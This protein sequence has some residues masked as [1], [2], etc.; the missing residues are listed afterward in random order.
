MLVLKVGWDVPEGNAFQACEIKIVM[1]QLR[2]VKIHHEETE[3]YKKGT[4]AAAA[5]F[6]LV[7]VFRPANGSLM[8]FLA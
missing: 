4:I 8:F 1:F 7:T 5:L 3:T 2:N 6:L